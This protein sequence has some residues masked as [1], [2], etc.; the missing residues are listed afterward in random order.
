LTR[1][2]GLSEQTG[3]FGLRQMRE[4]ALDLGG[5]LDIISSPGIGAEIIISLPPAAF[6]ESY[7]SN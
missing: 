2:I 4:R 5:T 6:S 3:H 7:A 1:R